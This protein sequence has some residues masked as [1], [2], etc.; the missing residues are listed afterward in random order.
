MA[1]QH[2]G[3][4]AFGLR[5]YRARGVAGETAL[6]D[7]PGQEGF[8]LAHH[9]GNTHGII[10]RKI[11]L[12]FLCGKRKL[13][14]CLTLFIILISAA[15]SVLRRLARRLTVLLPDG[16]RTRVGARHCGQTEAIR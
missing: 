7:Q 4:G 16:A 11:C 9:A 10:W 2:C 8:V 15:Q 5:G 6:R 3:A 1:G 14:V 12:L 13:K